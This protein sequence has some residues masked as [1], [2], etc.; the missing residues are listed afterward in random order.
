[1]LVLLD[2]NL[3]YR[4]RLLILRHEVRTVAYQ[5]WQALS[6]GELLSVAEEAGFAVMLTADQN[7]QY[8]QNIRGRKIAI[9]ILSNNELERIAAHLAQILTAID[10]VKPGEFVTVDIGS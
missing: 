4:L 1:M 3:P 7:I 6:N 9:I 8:Q 2:E 5:G 10:E